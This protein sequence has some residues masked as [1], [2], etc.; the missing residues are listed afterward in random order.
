M[1]HESDSPPAYTTHADIPPS[2]EATTAPAYT[3]RYTPT[4]QA[5][6]QSPTPRASRNLPPSRPL[7]RTDRLELT[8]QPPTSDTD[9]TERDEEAGNTSTAAGRSSKSG[10]CGN[11][12][13][14]IVCIY[15]MGLFGTMCATAIYLTSTAIALKDNSWWLKRMYE[16]RPTVTWTV[17]QTV[18]KLDSG[19]ASTVTVTADGYRTTGTAIQEGVV[20]VTETAWDMLPTGVRIVDSPTG[21]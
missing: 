6:S 9:R 12:V 21:V 4:E 10:D 17:T 14:L 18:T 19:L 20:T 3:P 16:A 13:A 1:L 8:N 15:L 11:C 2:S 5:E 7:Q